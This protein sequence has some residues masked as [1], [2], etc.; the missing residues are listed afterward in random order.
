MSVTADYSSQLLARASAELKAGRAAEAEALYRQVLAHAPDHADA[1]HFLGVCLVQSGRAQEGL[2]LIARSIPLAGGK[3]AY[4][5]NYALMLAQAGDL[6]AAERE[7]SEAVAIDPGNATSHGYL[8]MIR[9]QLGRLSEA[10]GTFR[11]ALERSPNDP[12]IAGNYGR[13][14]L[15]MGDTGAA[16]EWLRRSLEIEPRNAVAHSNLGSALQASGD[17]RA[18]V[19]SFR[20]AVEVDRGYAPGWYNLGLALRGVGDRRGSFEAMRNAVLAGP[21]FVPAWQEFAQEFSQAR[22][23]AWDPVAAQ[24]LAR[25]LLHPAIDAGP[26]AEAA[27]SLLVLDP[28]F[29]PVFRELRSQERAE[30]NRF[31]GERL[32]ALAHP[33]L[34]ALIEN[35][36]VPDAEFEEFLRALRSRALL[37]WR[38]KTLGGSP[39]LIELLCALALQCFLNEY[40]WP[41]NAE[42]S[43]AIARL[44]ESART[45]ATPT[46]LALLAAWRPLAGIDGL[47]RPVG[48]G[49]AFARMWLRQVEEPAGEARLRAEIPVLTPIEDEVSQSVR[50]QYE[51]NPY[52]RWQR[53][54]AVSPYPLGRRLRTLF[55]HL[56]PSRL[57]APEAPAILIAGCGTGYHVAI[58]ALLNP[59][60]KVLAIDLSRTSLAYAMRRCRELGIGNVHFAQADILRLGAIEDRF[61]LIE[62]AGV[63][64][65]LRDPLEG[66][67]VLVS[68]LRAG[69]FMKVALYSELARRGVVAARELIAQHGLDGELDNIR[70]ARQL[71]LAQPEDSPARWPAASADF[72]SA[73]GTRDLLLHVQEHRFTLAR[74]NE[75]IDSLGLEFLGFEFADP[76]VPHAYRQRFPEDPALTSLAQ[77]ETFEKSSPGVFS[78]MY[79]FWVRKPA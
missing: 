78:G 5:H 33:L 35:A 79:Q 16:L 75:A 28:A 44:I 60:A 41:E 61:D 22:F 72:Y 38:D 57:S 68:L 46:E 1:L 49:E 76:E 3:P 18:A 56:E 65:H 2:P 7:L 42:E 59:S 4:R 14:L 11:A 23:E 20:K 43:A 77:W 27:A 64:H 62:T 25:V 48:G 8:A 47:V 32:K 19:A 10:A 15:E 31:A 26:L 52:P 69:G 55:P 9:M 40:V 29:A 63:L 39:L 67:R 17:A 24:E 34:L 21:G 6:A 50:R 70:A 13:C 53:A 12:Y 37:A 73:S 45:G 66:W 71:V 30:V 51:Q 74:V 54:P 58:T 36:L